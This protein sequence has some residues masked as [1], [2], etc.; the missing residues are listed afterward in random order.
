MFYCINGPAGGMGGPWRPGQTMIVSS[1]QKTEI[2]R[3]PPLARAAIQGVQGAN[4][5]FEIDISKKEDKLTK[6]GG[7]IKSG[8]LI[9]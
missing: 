3:V 9:Q 7:A 4:V 1:G 8:V 2:V 5:D 6:F